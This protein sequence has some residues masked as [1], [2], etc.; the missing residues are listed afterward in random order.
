MSH[1]GS[2]NQICASHPCCG[3]PGRVFCHVSSGLGTLITTT[4]FTQAIRLFLGS[5]L[6]YAY[7]YL[8][9]KCHEPSTC[10][11]IN[12]NSKTMCLPHGIVDI[13][14][15]MHTPSQSLETTLHSPIWRKQIFHVPSGTA[16][17][18]KNYIIVFFLTSCIIILYLTHEWQRFQQEN[19]YFNQTSKL[20]TKFVKQNHE[21]SP[22]FKRKSITA[23]VRP[24]YILSIAQHFRF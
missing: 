18:Y 16:S 10:F 17:C 19:S 14:N 21:K 7:H 5:N 13:D 24:N 20:S 1:K 11:C 15:D 23:R 6:E 4:N 22:S 3:R 12:N 8:C 9:Q 2:K